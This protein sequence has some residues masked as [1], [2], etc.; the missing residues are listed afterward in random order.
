MKKTCEYCGLAPQYEKEYGFGGLQYSKDKSRKILKS[1]PMYSELI[2]A[3]DEEGKIYL[4]AD[5]GDDND[6]QFRWYPNFCP[7]CG[8]PLKAE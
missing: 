4:E 3:A 6:K 2:I 1:S 8:R 7:A 5:E